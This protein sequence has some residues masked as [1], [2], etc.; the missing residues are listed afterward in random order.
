MTPLISVNSATTSA[1]IPASA[2]A[3]A[4]GTPLFLTVV[5]VDGVGRATTFAD[6]SPVIVAKLPPIGGRVVFGSPDM[7]GP[8]APPTPAPVPGAPAYSWRTDPTFVSV[9]SLLVPR[10]QTI[11]TSLNITFEPFDGSASGGIASVGYCVGTAPG[12][13]DVVELTPSSVASV[14][15]LVTLTGLSLADGQTYY[16]SVTAVS[17]AGLAATI[18]SEPL[19]VDSRVPTT[20]YVWDGLASGPRSHDIECDVFGAPLAATWYGFA[21]FADLGLDHFEWAV[22][23]TP[24]GDDVLPFTNVGLASQVRIDGIVTASAA[25]NS[26]IL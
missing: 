7:L 14:V 4:P 5:A 15:T 20:G 19:I 9:A 2:I 26:Q 18:T 25:C 22:G 16:A 3:A 8:G 21:A 1:I 24:G 17:N 23:T 10:Y 6:V 13:C 12:T 11:T